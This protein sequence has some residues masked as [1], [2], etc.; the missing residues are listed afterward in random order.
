MPHSRWLNKEDVVNIHNGIWSANKKEWNR[1]IRR[2]T[3]EPRAC[4]TGV[5]CHRGKT[6]IVS[7]M[8]IWNSE[9]WYKW[10]YFQGRN[11]DAD[12]QSVG[13]WTEREWRGR[14]DELGGCDHYID[15]TMGKIASEAI[16]HRKFSSVLSDDL[17][18]RGD[19][20]RGW[21]GGKSKRKGI[22]VCI[23]LDLLHCTAE[24]NTTF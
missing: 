6:N 20:G 22:Y 18:S 7:L 3:D 23:W 13:M 16:S 19:R 4:P 21:M 11:R 9:E 2:D 14:W 15:T 5:K 17:E 12:R 10:T 24:S 8:H 1:V